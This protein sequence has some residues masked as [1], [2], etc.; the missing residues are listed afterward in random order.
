[1]GGDRVPGA[2]A[3][4]PNTDAPS[5]LVE[6]RFRGKGHDSQARTLVLLLSK[7]GG[8][9]AGGIGLTG[10]SGNSIMEGVEIGNDIWVWAG[11]D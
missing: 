2:Y 8:W 7:P 11:R 10:R 4:R 9:I 6:S 1:V 5:E 3:A